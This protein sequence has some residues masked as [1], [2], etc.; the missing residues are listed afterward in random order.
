MESFKKMRIFLIFTVLV[1]YCCVTTTHKLLVAHKKHSLLRHL[2]MSWAHRQALG[3]RLGP[4][5]LHSSL[6]PQEQWPR[7]VHSSCGDARG[8]RSKWTQAKPL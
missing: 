3:Y 1:S 4:Y 5:V 2:Q 7:L 8:A 6:G